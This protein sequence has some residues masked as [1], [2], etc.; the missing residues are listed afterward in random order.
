MAEVGHPV[1]GTML[2]PRW[3]RQVMLYVVTWLSLKL[4]LWVLRTAGWAGGP[5]QLPRRHPYPRPPWSSRFAIKGAAR[6][7]MSSD[8]R[9]ALPSATTMG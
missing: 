5:D 8:P 1:H 4:T 6:M 9:T 2:D 3:L 7:S